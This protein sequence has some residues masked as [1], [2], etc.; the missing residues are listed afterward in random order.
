MACYFFHLRKYRMVQERVA[1]RKFTVNITE[2]QAKVNWEMT[3][4][5]D[6]STFFVLSVHHG[7]VYKEYLPLITFF[8][9]VYLFYC[10]GS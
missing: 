5:N 3:L 10:A 8:F 4:K 2:T 7:M 6:P 1:S 9:L